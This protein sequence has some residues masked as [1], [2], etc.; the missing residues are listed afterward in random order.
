ML[1]PIKPRP[2]TP[3]LNGSLRR[4]LWADSPIAGPSLLG[5]GCFAIRTLSKSPVDFKNA[6]TMTA[7]MYDSCPK[8]AGIDLWSTPHQ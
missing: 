5:L 7:P 4:L 1:F 2:T 8:G 6:H 3:A